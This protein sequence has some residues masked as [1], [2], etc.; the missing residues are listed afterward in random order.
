MKARGCACVKNP[1]SPGR[2]QN[3]R[4]WCVLAAVQSRA[5]EDQE[6][7]PSPAVSAESAPWAP[8]PGPSLGVSGRRSVLAFHGGR[9]VYLKVGGIMHICVS[10]ANMFP[11]FQLAGC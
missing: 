4:A 3:P 1:W 2:G 6:C 7:G 8:T 10:F 9:G 5:S 11:N